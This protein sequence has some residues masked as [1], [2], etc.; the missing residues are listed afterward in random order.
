MKQVISLYILLFFCILSGRAQQILSL[1]DAV[2]IAL[3]N[4]Y[5]IQIARNSA[6]IDKTNNTL[7]NAGM[8]PEVVLNFG[9]ANNIN[10]TRQE[11]FSGDVREGNNVNTTNI[12][13]N[14]QLGWTVFDG[15][16]MFVN[17]DRLREIESAGQLNIMVQMESTIYQVMTAYYNIIQHKK[18]LNTIENAIALSL[19]RKALAEVK[20][21]LGSGSSLPILQ[22]EVD[23]N[24][25]SASLI[26]QN[27]VLKNSKI[28]L[29]EILG[30]SPDNDF[31]IN[32]YVEPARL[33]D[34]QEMLSKAEK[35]NLWLQMADKTINISQFNI[36]QWEA[37]KYPTINVNLG[38]NISRL[39]A[40]IGILKF[41]Q[42]L[43]FSYGLTGRWNIFS[44]FNNKREI[45]VAKLNLETGKLTKEQSRLGIQTDLFTFYNNYLTAL[46]MAE[47]EKKNIN[48]AREN[49]NITS[50]RLRIGS[51]QPI[52]LRQ[53]QLNLVDAEFRKI[54]AEF[55]AQMAG[56]EMKRLTG[57]L[58]KN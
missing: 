39:N 51:I 46:E 53:A 2:S 23:I 10:N 13:A 7:G 42:N 27:L 9:N 17:R 49:L 34:Y 47:V 37:N 6:L 33:P 20:Q 30:R 22:A 50:E 24:A 25:D 3:Q 16:R 21:D 54:V 58:I 43:G 31:E 38:Y 35:N 19:D 1:E 41:N 56:L 45:Q 52:E 26:R 18:R 57:E 36:K 28:M 5:N 29:N 55:D 12:N 48:I 8:L 4:N 44:G 14:V 40:E 32:D 15:M 11:F